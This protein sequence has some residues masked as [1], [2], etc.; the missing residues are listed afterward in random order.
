MREKI[1][2]IPVNDAFA[3]GDEC[4]FCYLEREA[5]QRAVKYTIGPGASYMEPEIRA[6][7][8]RE[9]FCRHHLKMMQAYGNALGCALILQ[10][11]YTGILMKLEEELDDYELPPKRG[12]LR[13]KSASVEKSSLITWL[14]ETQ[15]SCFVC[16]QMAE[17][18]QRYFDTFFAMLKDGEFRSK[19]EH[20]KGFC[21]HHFLQLL[22]EAENSLPNGQREWFREKLP[23]LMRE[24]LLRVKGD[25]DWFVM[26]NDYRNAG[27][28]WKNARDAVSRGMQKLQG[29]HPADPVFRSSDYGIKIP[30]K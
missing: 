28:E 19:V 18:M 9:G 17:S 25:L 22:E 6:I 2:T 12:L 3:S 20:S 23:E 24:N 21:M 4:P 16:K 5:E 8:D 7:T 30:G 14:Q 1:D 10:T 29:G 26:K 13:K 11:Y 15:E 27:K